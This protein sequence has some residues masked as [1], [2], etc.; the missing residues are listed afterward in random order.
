MWV[1]ERRQVHMG[2]VGLEMIAGDIKGNML[3]ASGN[4][5]LAKDQAKI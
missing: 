5:S 1:R 3:Q 2:R 4:V